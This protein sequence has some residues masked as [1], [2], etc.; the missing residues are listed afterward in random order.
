MLIRKLLNF[1]AALR[2]PHQLWSSINKSN[3][4]K[5]EGTH[6]VKDIKT[7]LSTW[8]KLLIYYLELHDNEFKKVIKRYLSKLYPM[9][10]RY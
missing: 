9:S 5:I 4:G 3:E 2:L 8:F 6:I 1:Y 10:K 7:A